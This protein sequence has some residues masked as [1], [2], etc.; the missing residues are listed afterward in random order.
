MAVVEVPAPLTLERL[1]AVVPAAAAVL[2]ALSLSDALALTAASKSLLPLRSSLPVIT[3]DGARC[4]QL[5]DTAL[6]SLC[7][8][9]A[10]ALRRLDLIGALPPHPRAG[11]E[12]AEGVT[13]EGLVAVLSGAPPPGLAVGALTKRRSDEAL[14]VSVL[15]GAAAVSDLFLA[16]FMAGGGIPPAPPPRRPSPL[17]SLAA[18]RTYGGGEVDP[19]AAAVLALPPGPPLRS[20]TELVCAGARAAPAPC[21]SPPPRLRSW[22]APAP[23]C[24]ACAASPRS[25]TCWAR[26]WSARAPCPPSPPCRPS[27]PWHCSS[28][29]GLGVAAERVLARA[30]AA[31]ARL[32]WVEARCDSLRGGE[33]LRAA[34]AARA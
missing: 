33:L 30:V 16:A 10:G 7:R 25:S 6:A 29:T 14:N 8:G 17:A 22:R 28:P 11:E 34:A 18:R 26:R 15:S 32:A 19:K 12:K 23:A 24:R 9:C 1:L 31:D 5:M 20:L 13:A 27:A 2:S 21:P 4:G 3:F